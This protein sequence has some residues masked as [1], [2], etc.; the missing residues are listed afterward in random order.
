MT[1]AGEIV[2][3]DEISLDPL[4]IVLADRAFEVVGVRNRLLRP[5]TLMIVQNEHCTDSRARGRSS[6]ANRNP[7]D[8]PRRQ[9]WRRL[10]FSEGRS[11]MKL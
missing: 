10:A 1:V 8:V 4:R 7:P 5:C 9:H 3:G 2:V 6:T 11:S